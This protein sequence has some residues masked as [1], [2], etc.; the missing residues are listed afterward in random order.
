MN[1]IQEKIAL[2]SKTVL[3]TGAGGGIGFEAAKAFAKMGAKIIIVEVNREKG[4]EATEYINKL[5][6]KAAIF[7]HIDLSKEL[8][9]NQLC[10]SIF[11]K[12]G[13]PNI[14]F[15]N[16]TIAPL[17]NI[18][19][20]DIATW[21][22]SYAVNLKA[23][24]MFTT[25]FLPHIKKRNDGCFVFV[26]SSGAAPYMSAY[27]TFKTAQVEFSNT[28]AIEL[29]GTN[30]YAY[31][32][33]PGLVKTRTAEK[34]IEIIASKMDISTDEFYRM[35]KD[36]ILNVEAAGLGFALSVLNAEKYHGQ[37]IS[38][39][40]VLNDF[41]FYNKHQDEN[42]NATCINKELL[43]K[44]ITTFEEQYNGWKKMNIFERQWVFRDF[45]KYMG[46]SAD[47]VQ[48]DLLKIKEQLNN[49]LKITNISRDLFVKLQ[50][51]WEHQLQ[52]LQGYEKDPNKLIEKNKIIAE[53][54][55]DIK[56]L[57]S[58]LNL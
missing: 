5:Y 14:I 44:I 11:S 46:V 22:N 9:V 12:Y 42:S 37:E 3:L 35:N 40:Q 28:L 27:E 51:Y 2:A 56:T 32:I 34:S 6:P 13:C 26:S 20:I 15:N 10:E 17:G 38:S 41:N 36:Y 1:S 29:E 53:W 48:D 39:I 54:I 47:M 7:Y 25:F 4:L 19:E 23:P 52:L 43:S 33:S 31:T 50:S 45:K 24:I 55:Y 16:A 21:D 57:L 58:L 49:S 30:I 8:Q 18:E